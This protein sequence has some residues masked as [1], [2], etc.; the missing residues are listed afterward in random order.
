MENN[1]RT[2]GARGE[3]EAASYLKNKGYKIIKQ[4]FHFGKTGEIDIVASKDDVLVFVEVKTRYSDKYG[5]PLL[6]ITYNKQRSIRK[7]AEGYLYINKI[8]D[9]ECRFDVIII[10]KRP[11]TN[12]IL[13]M[14]NAF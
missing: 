2:V 5:D 14:E 12:E 3:E 13:H 10:D 11:G 1:N 4:N 9:M 7:V 6:S 8:T